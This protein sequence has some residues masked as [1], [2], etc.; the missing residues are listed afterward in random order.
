MRKIFIGITCSMMLFACNSKSGQPESAGTGDTLSAKSEAKTPPQAELV[1]MKYA[2]AGKKLL[3]SISAGDI[4]GLVSIF[5]D[6]AVYQWS[7]GDSLTGKDAIKK[8]WADRRTNVIDSIS[9][10]NDIWLP[11]KVNK[12]QK[13]PDAPGIWLLGWF[14]FDTKYKN[15]KK[16]MGWVHQDMHFNA[17]G[18]VDRSIQYIDRAPINAAT[19]AKK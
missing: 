19:A 6:N 9:F 3:A 18:K 1:D 11:I 15:G 12:P 2:D 14:Q 7:S 13:G 4:D 10:A 8:Y 17:D 5:A 16:L